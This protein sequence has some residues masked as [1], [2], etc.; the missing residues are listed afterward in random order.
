MIRLSKLYP[1]GS[2]FI[3]S[4]SHG[5]IARRDTDFVQDPEKDP[6]TSIRECLSIA[7]RSCSDTPSYARLSS[8][9]GGRAGSAARRRAYARRK[10][11]RSR[12]RREGRGREGGA[13]EGGER[14]KEGAEASE[15]KE[16]RMENTVSGERR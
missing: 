16:T 6:K 1:S 3:S 9:S 7:S 11:R 12:T 4:Q 15:A 13:G 14:R 10:E 2:L 8:L 5:E